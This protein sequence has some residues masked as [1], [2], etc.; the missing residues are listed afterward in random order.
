M[1][2][3]IVTQARIGSTRLP[4]KVLKEIEGISI[5]GM[6]LKRVKKSTCYSHIIVATTFEEGVEKIIS[7]AS[8]ELVRVFQGDLNDVLKRF[9]EAVKEEAPDYVV[10]VTS[11]CPLIDGSI[12]DE[13]VKTCI[14]IKADYLCTAE[15]FP[16]GL[17]VE[18]FTFR[19][20]EEANNKAVK[21]YEREH[22]TPWIKEYAKSNGTY[23]E[24][25]CDLGY[26]NVRM[27]VDEKLDFEAI[28]Q[29][30]NVFGGNESWMTYANY[31]LNN[32]ELFPNQ[33]IKRNEGFL[34]SIN[35][36]KK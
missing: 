7:V 11:D 1:K 24:H 27:T 32:L 26:C 8:D 25:T 14:L 12:I 15:S 36:E 4:G 16:D 18:V 30:L 33:S 2:V 31:I 6:H 3:I 23:Y 9:Y 22:V 13:C 21:N 10:R 35:E 28:K 17:D 20:L 5:L 19:L 34:K 29:L